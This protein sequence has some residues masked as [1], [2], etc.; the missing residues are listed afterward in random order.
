MPD[1]KGNLYLSE[2]IELRNEYDRH[3]KLLQDLTAE[4]NDKGDRF[5]SRSDGD[6]D[7]EPSADFKQKELVERL[8]RLQTKRM[9]LN[10]EIQAANFKTEIDYDGEKI[11]IAEALE[12]RKN[13][14]AERESISQRVKISAYTRIIHKEE[15]DIVRKPK[16]S[17]KETYQEFQENLKK[18]RHVVNQIHIVNHTAVVSFKDE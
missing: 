16:D 17:F 14:I 8:K 15:R 1:R 12:V 6:E 5:F 7:K 18:L 11:G 3:I 9:K 4:A 2:A 10:Q 13:L